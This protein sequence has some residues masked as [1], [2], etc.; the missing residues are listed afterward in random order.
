MCFATK[1]R[2]GAINSSCRG[3]SRRRAVVRE[4]HQH[5]HQ[6]WQ[7]A[8]TTSTGLA[9][10]GR[11]ACTTCERAPPTP[12][13]VVACEHHHH[14]CHQH[15]PWL[16]RASGACDGQ[17]RAMSERAVWRGKRDNS[18][19][20]WACLSL[21]MLQPSTRFIFSKYMLFSANIGIPL[22]PPTSTTASSQRLICHR[23]PTLRST[24]ALP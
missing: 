12:V 2:L 24:L 14:Q 22:P 6:Q 23:R 3:R 21:M 9:S 18:E 5:Q 16:G 17:E 8:S 11:A 10:P 20:E 7:H 19:V 15:R 4:H 1:G 13:A